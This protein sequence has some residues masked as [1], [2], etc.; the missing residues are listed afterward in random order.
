MPTVP[1]MPTGPEDPSHPG[2]SPPTI[3]IVM[4]III[5]ILILIAI[6][7]ARRSSHRTES[8]ED[9]HRRLKKGSGGIGVNALRLLPLVKYNPDVMGPDF[10]HDGNTSPTGLSL[11]RGMDMAVSDTDGGDKPSRKAWRDFYP[12]IR[13]ALLGKHRGPQP[14]PEDADTTSLIQTCVICTDDFIRGTNVRR[15]PCGHFFHPPC[16]DPWLLNFG[17]TCPLCRTN[18]KMLANANNQ[19]EG[20]VAEPPRAMLA[21]AGRI[22]E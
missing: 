3:S 22:E 9:S 20:C 11:L 6:F 4:C 7:V 10:H 19:N 21:G 5:S 8:H 17:V 15:L 12:Q 2:E 13:H 14:C 18:L 1:G 16:I